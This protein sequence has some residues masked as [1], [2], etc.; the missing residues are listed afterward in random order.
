MS[1]LGFIALTDPDWHGFLSR[2]PNV[3]EVNFWQPNGGR[4]F[5]AVEPGAPFFFKLRAPQRKIAGFGFFQRHEILPARLAWE[6][7]GP[8]NGAATFAELL[9]RLRRLRAPG[10][11]DRQDFTIGCI[12]LAAPVFFPE[13]DWVDAPSDWPVTGVQVGKRYDVT[14]GEGRRVVDA[15][16]A[17]ALIANTRWNVDRAAEPQ[18]RYGSPVQVTPRLGQGLFSFAVRDAYNGACAVTREHSV[19]VLEAAHIKPYALGGEHRLENGLLLR[20][21]LHKLFD[22]G[23]VTVTPDCEFRVGE[24]LRETWQNG[25]TYYAMDSTRIA[26]PEAGHPRPDRQLLEWHRD[27]VFLG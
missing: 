9:D 6:T 20:A 1:T 2:Q 13:S 24:S 12:M 26:A 11:S 22:A 14:T 18:P 19:P 17:R 23:Y 4:A 16:M 21:D 7:F 15:C 10:E 8:M 3:D 27:M 5:R 25:K